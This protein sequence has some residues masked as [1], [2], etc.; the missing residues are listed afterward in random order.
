MM[1]VVTPVHPESE[2]QTQ[3]PRPEGSVPVAEI[4]EVITP[5]PKRKVLPNWHLPKSS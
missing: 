3:W 1:Y 5:L 4:E 2:N